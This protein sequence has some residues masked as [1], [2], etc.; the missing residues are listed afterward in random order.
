MAHFGFGEFLCHERGEDHLRLP[1]AAERR[2]FRCALP[3]WALGAGGAAPGAAALGAAARH[4]L[5][6][7]RR[8]ALPGGAMI[9][10]ILYDT[11][12]TIIYS[13]I[14]YSIIIYCVT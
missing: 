6:L 3:P 5:A 12:N 11:Y 13:I 14:I 10:D 9:Y 4:A 7:R 8:E 1:L 2:L